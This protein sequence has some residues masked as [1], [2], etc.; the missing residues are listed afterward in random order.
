LRPYMKEFDP[1]KVSK[2]CPI[3]NIRLTWQSTL[4]D[5]NDPRKIPKTS[6]HHKPLPIPIHSY[7]QYP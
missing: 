2:R 7:K 5:T 6:M 1:E 4:Q 3:E